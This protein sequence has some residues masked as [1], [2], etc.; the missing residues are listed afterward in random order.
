MHALLRAEASRIEPGLVSEHLSWGSFGGR[1]SNDLL[2]LPRTEEALIHVS[3][4]IIQVQEYL[5]RSISIE[6]VSSYIEFNDSV[7]PEAEFLVEVARR[8]GCGILLDI[9][10]LYVNAI[11][12]S[13][14][15]SLFIE[16]IP[17]DLV[18]EFHLA[19]HS[20][21][22]FGGHELL[23]DTHNTRVCAEVWLLYRQAVRR[24][25]RIPTLIEWDSDLPALEVLLGEADLAQRM[26]DECHAIAA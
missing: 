12:Q 14:D 17:V 20:M 7:L 15:A 23:I 2:P 22:K 11:N 5:G 25:G 9:N 18:T 6:N 24:F 1:H 13:T 4:K 10:N 8:S 16:S 3:G 21:Q 26:M 19:G